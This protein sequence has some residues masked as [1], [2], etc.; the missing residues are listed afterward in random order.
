MAEP[1]LELV[2]HDLD[3]RRHLGGEHAGLGLHRLRNARCE[4]CQE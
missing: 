1:C 3:A 2:G 4:P